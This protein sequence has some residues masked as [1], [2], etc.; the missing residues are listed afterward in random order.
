MREDGTAIISSAEKSPT[1]HLV[2]GKAEKAEEEEEG[3]TEERQHCSP[4]E[5]LTAK[6]S[7]I[8]QNGEAAPAAGEE[9]SDEQK[10]QKV[11]FAGI[12]SSFLL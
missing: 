12:G 3:E 10:R 7:R 1:E 5:A 11:N 2:G 4:M 9:V 8:Q 6:L